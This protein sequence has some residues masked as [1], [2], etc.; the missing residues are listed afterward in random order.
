[1]VAT[2]KSGNVLRESPT[3]NIF[4]DFNHFKIRVSH[5]FTQ[6]FRESQQ[7]EYDLVFLIGI[8]PSN[9][10]KVHQRKTTVIS[11]YRW[12][13]EED[14]TFYVDPTK[15]TNTGGTTATTVVPI[16]V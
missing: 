9:H 14:R 13:I 15:T 7:K 16:P 3:I 4:G 2:N 1:M 12:I 8:E 6:T 5:T 11:D 10:A